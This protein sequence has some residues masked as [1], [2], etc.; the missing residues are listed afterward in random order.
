MAC[1]L[2]ITHTAPLTGSGHTSPLPTPFF[3]KIVSLGRYSKKDQ[4]LHFIMYTRHSH[5][6]NTALRVQSFWVPHL[7]HQT[8]CTNRSRS[9]AIR[10]FFKGGR[11]G[12][13]WNNWVV[14][15]LQPSLNICKHLF[16]I[17]ICTYMD[18]VCVCVIK[19]SILRCF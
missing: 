8:H 3:P 15:L 11:C 13:A 1:V 9:L 18:I 7:E 5:Y 19:C 16:K 4:Q 6:Q 12:N 2:A 17:H 10:K 14:S